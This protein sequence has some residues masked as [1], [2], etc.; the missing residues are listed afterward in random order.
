MEK[1]CEKYKG[2]SGKVINHEMKGKDEEIH[3]LV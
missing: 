2:E 1:L 3:N